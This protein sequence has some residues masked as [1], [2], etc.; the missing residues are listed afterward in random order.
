MNK[1]ETLRT[2]T[3]NE[4]YSDIDPSTKDSDQN[5]SFAQQKVAK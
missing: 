4:R 1:K 5:V 2:L 3:H